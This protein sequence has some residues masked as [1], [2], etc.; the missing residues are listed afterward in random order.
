M[1]REAALLVV[2][3]LRAGAGRSPVL[4]GVSFEVGAGEALALLG[5]EGAGKTTLMMAIAGLI[6][7]ASG[8]VLLDGVSI[9]GLDS[10]RV[11]NLGI[12]LVPEGRHVFPALSV[13]EN[14]KAGATIPRARS[15]A[16]ELFERVY[17]LFPR[18]AARRDQIAG[19]L[20]GGEQQLLSIGRCLM[21]APRLIMLDEPAQGLAETTRAEV[22][23]VLA[24]L[25]AEGMAMLLA[26]PDTE[27]ALGFAD[28]TLV[29]AEGRAVP[30]N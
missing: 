23:A 30:A 26:E 3:E 24:A 2:R 15:S 17:E 22:Y 19:T 18:L 29:L 10:S 27:V 9:A 21:S 8:S 1:S 13:A 12:A 14:L 20:S 28:R 11:C 4:T 6:R 16:R 7:P 5:E 25:R